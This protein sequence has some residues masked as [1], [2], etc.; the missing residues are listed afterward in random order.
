MSAE[1]PKKELRP[2]TVPSDNQETPMPVQMGNVA[3][4][5]HYPNQYMWTGNGPREVVKNVAFP[6]P[7]KGTPKVT[8]AL[9]AVDASKGSNLRVVVSCDAITDH[10]F[11]IKVS[12]YADS[13]IASASVSWIATD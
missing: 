10:G 4:F 8:A 9:S 11:N 1:P 3:V 6:K 2:H 12:T 13:A 7:F 5:S